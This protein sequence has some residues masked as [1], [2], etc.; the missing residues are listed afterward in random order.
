[1]ITDMVLIQKRLESIENSLK[2]IEQFLVQ[3][4]TENENE[5]KRENFTRFN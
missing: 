5:I 4:A 1:M 3:N 2:N